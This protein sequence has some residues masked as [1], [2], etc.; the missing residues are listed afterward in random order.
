MLHSENVQ[1]TVVWTGIAYEFYEFL[2][3]IR[4]KLSAMYFFAEQLL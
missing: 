3:P 4:P 1:M 2:Y